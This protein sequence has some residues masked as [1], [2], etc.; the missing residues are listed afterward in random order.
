MT[1]GPITDDPHDG[2][3]TVTRRGIFE[4]F[5]IILLTQALA[6]H[7]AAMGPTPL[8]NDEVSAKIEMGAELLDG[9]KFEE[10]LALFDDVIRSNPD[11]A[12][13]WTGFAFAKRRLGDVEGAWPA[14]QRALDLDP[15]HKGANEYIG[16]LYLRIGQPEKAQEH[17]EVLNRVCSLGC[18]ERTELAEAIQAYHMSKGAVRPE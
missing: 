2:G 18:E 17:L 11:N 12:D 7:A 5:L 15:D 3:R 16:E 9:E 14:Y 13:A 10:A 1:L 4:G 8:G 6:F